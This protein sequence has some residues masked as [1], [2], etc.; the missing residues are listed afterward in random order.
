MA[1]T[2]RPAHALYLCDNGRCLCGLH[3]G[4]SAKA[5]GRDISGQ[6]IYQIQPADHEVGTPPFKCETCKATFARSVRQGVVRPVLVR[7]T[8][9][10]GTTTVHDYASEA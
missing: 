4:S 10:R 5:T 9:K 6:R 8:G 1:K 3:L 2:S 7:E